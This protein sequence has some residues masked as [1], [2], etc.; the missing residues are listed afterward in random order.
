VP[1]DSSIQKLTAA[2]QRL[3]HQY[4]PHHLVPAT[5]RYIN[6]LAR[7]MG[8]AGCVVKLLKWRPTEKLALKLIG[9]EE[10]RR[11]F[12]A[13]LHNTAVPTVIRAGDKT[14]V[15]PAIA[16]C[17]I[18]GRYLP[19]FTE[20]H[21]LAEVRRVIGNG[22]DI[23]VMRSGPPSSNPIDTPLYRLLEDVIRDRT[24]GAPVIPWILSGLTD[25]RWLEELGIT[26]Y[27]FSPVQ[28][29]ANVQFSKLP[30]GHD[31][32]IPLAGFAWGMETFWTAVKRFVEG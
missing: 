29:P 30:H 7:E 3:T 12:I 24:G 9:N 31:E 17:E 15:V 11:T 32:R 26:V 14:N 28:F 19:G 21:F 13:S 18:D 22:F 8:P 16:E 25:S 6:A 10:I 1:S 20:E 4:L 23:E 27:G 5:V 2:L